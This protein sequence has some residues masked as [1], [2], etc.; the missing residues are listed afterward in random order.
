MKLHKVNKEGSIAVVI[1]KDIASVLGWE[2][3][4]DVIVNMTDNDCKLFLLNMTKMR[5]NK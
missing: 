4:Q 3:G 5:E 1:P 2:E